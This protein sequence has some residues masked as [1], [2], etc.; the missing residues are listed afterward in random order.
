MATL[1]QNVP[2]V[3]AADARRAEGSTARWRPVLR[4]IAAELSFALG[5]FAICAALIALRMALVQQQA[6]PRE[7]ALSGF[8][9]ATLAAIAAFVSAGYLRTRRESRTATRG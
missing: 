8:G 3:A 9:V 2:A 6:L 5:L 7:L 4:S 1:A